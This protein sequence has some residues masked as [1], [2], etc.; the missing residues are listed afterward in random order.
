ME[1]FV[2][3]LDFIKTL[4]VQPG[5]YRF[6]AKDELDTNNSRVSGELLY[7]GKAINL[8]NR[9]KSYFQKSQ[10]LS[11]RISLMIK[12]IYR[13]E[14]TIT[15]NEVSALLLENNLIKSLKPKYNIIFRDDKT[16]PLIRLTKHEYPKI[17]S[18][19]GK[20]TGDNYFGPYPNFYAV[21]Y[22]IDTIQNLFK[23]RTCSD[24]FF[25]HRSRPCML[26]QI[27]R[28]TAPCVGYVNAEEYANQ[29]ALAV[30]FLHGD[31]K[32]IVADLN[33]QMNMAAESLEFE[34]AA[35]IRDKIGLLQQLRQD[36][37][38]NNHKQPINADVVLAK[39]HGAKLFV[40]LINL[41]QGIY[42]GDCNFV[43]PSPDDDQCGILKVFLE[44]YYLERQAVNT[45]YV[46]MDLD[47]E[48]LQIFTA[49]TKIKVTGKMPA[50][51]KRLYISMGQVNLNKVIDGASQNSQ[52]SLAA[53]R[54]AQILNLDNINRIE[55]IDISHNRGT[56]AMAS[57]VVY[58]NSK[59]DNSKYRRYT[60]P[61]SVGGDDL[62][63]IRTMLERRLKAQSL[64]LPEVIVVDGGIN[65][66]N[67]VKNILIAHG[68]CDKIRVVSIYKGERRDPKFDRV[69]IDQKLILEA[70]GEPVVFKL[71]Q[72][73]RDE[74][75][76]F[77]ITGHR[78]KQVKSM[79]GSGINEIANI[80]NVKKRIL[81]A[82]FGSIRG[83]ANASIED[84]RQTNG[85]G[86]RLAKNIYYHFH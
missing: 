40:Y 25:N 71:L 66:F 46:D 12:K 35:N 69:I 49:A 84:L 42:S 18:Y 50:E 9:V 10:A 55:C 21:R 36:Q 79:T 7:V 33:Q 59:I 6:Y 48:F 60:L 67:L 44:G 13:I 78:K 75:H 54:L 4:P 15:D 63:G 38:I 57:L 22:T 32:Q 80:G 16:Y 70:A 53:E 30:R 83:I 65:Q 20:N 2:N 28:C 41:R 23:L 29:V 86:D 45:I 74:A 8:A 68:L 5:V 11:P 51:V 17:D 81:I 43:L 52:L 47:S 64:T 58:E 31:Y 76:R 39:S 1:I 26:Y 85:I 34:L 14:L 37:I 27:K 24:N 19:R 82:R 3:K 72:N 56:N 73:L 77:A 61:D 62:L